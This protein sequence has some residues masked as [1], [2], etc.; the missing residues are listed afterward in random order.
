MTGSMSEQEE[1]ERKA[2]ALFNCEKNVLNY[3]IES[4]GTIGARESVKKK[5]ME[6]IKNS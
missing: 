1:L 3:L 6:Q 4:S 5:V 2:K